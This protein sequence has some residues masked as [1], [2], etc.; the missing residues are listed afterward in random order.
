MKS[1]YLK[2][3]AILCLVSAIACGVAFAWSVTSSPVTIIANSVY[4]LTLSASS[5][6]VNVGDTVT[7]TATLT[8]DGV[9]LSGVAITLVQEGIPEQT[10]PMGLTNSA[11]QCSATWIPTTSGSVTFHATASG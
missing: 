7:F 1:K 9:A 10:T 5:T 4:A 11:G 3:L 8:R 2:F 6:E